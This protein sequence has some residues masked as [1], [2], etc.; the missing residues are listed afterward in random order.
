MK[1]GST[2]I[3]TNILLAPLA[4]CSDLAFRSIAREH[5]AKFCFF[6]MIDT[7]AVVYGP[8]FRTR[9]I[10]KTFES[11]LPIAAQL[12]G[13]EPSMM[14]KAAREIIESS[15]I[16]FLDINAACPAKKAIK[17][18]TGAYLLND[19]KTLNKVIKALAAAL[20]VPVTV[21]IRIGYDT[22]DI[23]SLAK[24]A[25]GCESSGASAIFVHGRTRVQQYAGE[26]DYAAIKAV[27]ESVHIPVIGSGNIFDV[28][29]AKKMFTET[30]CDAINVARGALG[31]PWIFSQIADYIKNGTLPTAIN[32]KTRIDVL[33]RHLAYIDRYKEGRPLSKVGY[34]RKVVFWYARGFPNAPRLRGQISVVKSY[35]MM[36]K[37]ID[38]I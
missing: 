14:L 37:L 5:G 31:N 28:G 13:R 29:S 10:L 17:K 16:S 15:N 6:E 27:K 12:L 7:N 30:G 32:T 2:E 11:D 20:P 4:G 25:K 33:K 3:P 9:Y 26:I 24:L 36:L 21:K 1:I 18:K 38:S 34:M 19:G 22:T 23:R 8:K 35:E